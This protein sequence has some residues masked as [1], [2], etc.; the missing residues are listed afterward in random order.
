MATDYD[1]IDVVIPARNEADT[2]GSVLSVFKLHPAIGTVIV[3]VDK[4]TGDDTAEVARQ[5]LDSTD[6]VLEL[7]TPSGKGQCVRH[8][9]QYVNTEYVM[10]CDSDLK[11][12]TVDHIS[13]LIYHATLGDDYLTIGV[14]DIPK[15]YPTERIWAWPWVSGERCVP[16]K[17]VQPLWLHGYLMETQINTAARHADMP[18]NFQWLRGLQASYYMSERRIREMVRDAEFGQTHGILL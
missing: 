2:I 15:N 6:M 3:V 8:A 13:R 12:L 9:M 5:A 18:L 1:R 11:G 14:P 7:F 17:L 16:A 4:D 10:F